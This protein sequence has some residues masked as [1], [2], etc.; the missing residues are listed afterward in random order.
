MR[1]RNFPTT[2]IEEIAIETDIAN[3]LAYPIYFDSDG[4]RPAIAD[5]AWKKLS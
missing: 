2:P 5:E 1:K 3:S 4:L